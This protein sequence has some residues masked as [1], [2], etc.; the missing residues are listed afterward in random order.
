MSTLI[1]AGTALAVV[2]AGLG[3]GPRAQPKP[4]GPPAPAPPD[5]AQVAMERK[6]ASA[7]Y[8]Q[9]LVMAEVGRT[10]RVLSATL[11]RDLKALQAA[12]AKTPG[13]VNEVRRDLRLGPPLRE[14]CRLRWK[15]GITEL[16]EHGAQ[17]LGDAQCE[18][19]ARAQNGASGTSG[20]RPRQTTPSEIRPAP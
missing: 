8:Q 3:C 14:A 16:L 2:M 4:A 15:E 10:H 5:P 19:C 18:A 9:E 11:G 7:K 13:K 1:V 12:L 6:R 20:E 17:C